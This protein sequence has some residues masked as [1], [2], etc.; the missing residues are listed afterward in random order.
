MM[1]T[2]ED[3]EITESCISQCRAEL[4]KQMSE[5]PLGCLYRSDKIHH[6]PVRGGF[7]YELYPSDD[8]ARRASTIFKSLDTAG[9]V[10]TRG[11]GS[12]LKA[13]MAW[14]HFEFMDA[15]CLFL[16]ISLDAAHSITL[17]KLRD[18]GVVNPTS[19]DAARFFDEISGFPTPWER[20]FE[21]D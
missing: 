16:W 21:W 2:S 8:V 14:R 6:S 5:D 12:L 18:A 11:V 17:Q 15:A 3:Q 1:E 10:M 9:P 13:N 7:D 4:I 20:F 19:V